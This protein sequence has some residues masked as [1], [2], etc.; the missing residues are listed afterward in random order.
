MSDLKERITL[1]D[2]AARKLVEE[3]LAGLTEK[4]GGRLTAADV[5]ED[6][7]DQSSPLHDFFEWDDGK[8]AHEHRLE[9]AGHLIRTVR[10][11]VT[12]EKRTISVVKYVR[13][14]TEKSGYVE[15]LR[16]RDQKDLA[17]DAIR[18]E[19]TRVL[20]ALERAQDI[21]E[22]LGVEDEIQDIVTRVSDLRRRVAA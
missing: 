14:P 1:R 20:A 7:K 15:T 21:A 12:T 10:V 19:I 9:Q 8:A 16:L 13:D 2:P 3:R 22:A 5:L 6:A 4:S 11:E 18:A 17:R